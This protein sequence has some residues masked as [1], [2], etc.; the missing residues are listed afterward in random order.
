MADSRQATAPML[1]AIASIFTAAIL[2]TAWASASG[3][4]EPEWSAWV[5]SPAGAAAI[6]ED[7][8]VDRPAASAIKPAILEEFFAAHA[9][10]LDEPPPSAPAMLGDDQHPGM[11]H[12]P[13]EV[14]EEI[15]RGLG[16]AS[17]REIGRI[18]IH[19]EGGSNAVYNAA[20]NVAIDALG[21]P[22][23]TTRAIHRRDPAFGG[24]HVRRYM[25][26]ARD[27]T[28]DNTATAASLAAVLARL[29]GRDVPGL[30]A[31]TVEAIRAALFLEVD[32]DR[33]RHF[34]KSGAL[35]TI[36]MTR[37]R[38][39]WYESDDAA[40]VYVV[41]GSIDDPGDLDPSALG[42]RLERRVAARTEELLQDAPTPD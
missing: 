42:D 35:N 7:A 11:V 1:A 27:V 16:G 6:D 33:G 9:G 17:V 41:M 10:A 29:A 4:I 8:E 20:S 5:G 36:P 25:L 34:F 23:A 39:G 22:E 13:S 2:G 40:I 19:D 14:R 12:F 28:G 30:D 24:L 3:E 15:R 18:M 32:P 38:S 31:E 37:I 21:G 26:A